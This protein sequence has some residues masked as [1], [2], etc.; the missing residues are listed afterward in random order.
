MIHGIIKGRELRYT[1]E[2]QKAKCKTRKFRKILFLSLIFSFAFLILNPYIASAEEY[3]DA[4]EKAI[5]LYENGDFD[6]AI[7]EFK[8]VISELR[9]KPEN[10]ARNEKLFTANF[11]VG[12]AY[13]G[14]G[15]EGL[16]KESFRNA[17]KAAPDKTINPELFPPKVISLYNEVISQNL[18]S[19]FVKSNVAEAE[20][21]VDD[22]KKGNAPV[23]RN[24]MPGTRTVK[25]VAAGQEIIKIVHLE[26]GKDVNI[27]AEFQTIGSLSIIS[28]PTVATVYLNGKLVG[29]TPL[30]LKDIPVGEHTVVISK[31]GYIESTQKAIVKGSEITE[32]IIRLAPVIYSVRLFSVPENAEVFWDETARGATPLVIENITAGIHK[33][34]IVKE[35][36]EEQKDTIDV[37]IPVTEKTYRLTPHTGSLSIKTDPPGVEVIIDNRNIGATPLTVS[38]LPV[39]Q[40]AVKLKKEGYKGKDVKVGIAKDKTAEINEVL[41]ELDAQSP[42]IILEPPSKAVKE[43]KNF[44]RARIMDNQAVGEVSLMLKM[45]GEMNFQRVGMSSPLKGTYEAVIPDAY[46]KKGAVLEYYISAC[47]LQSNCAAAG[48]KESPHKLKVISLEPYT[49]GFIIDMDMENDMVKISLGSVDGVKK[50]DKYIVFRIGKE[51][52]DPKTNELLQIEEYLIG[53]IKVKELMPRTASAEIDE[54]ESGMFKNDRVRKHASAV[55]GVI[56][57]GNYAAKITLRWAP[58]REPEV[59]GYRIYRSPKIDGIYQRAGEIDG[60]DNTSFEDTEDM[61]EGIS[62]YYTVAAFN[63]MGTD[64]I[65]SEPVLGKTKSGVL[66]PENVRVE[67]VKINQVH[68]RWSISRQDPDI[69][70]YIIFRSETEVGQFKE[71]GRVDRETDSYIDKEDIRPGKIYFYRLAGK[72]K[73]GSTGPLSR[74]VIASIKQ[75]PKAPTG[76]KGEAVQGKVLLR[77]EANK[78]PDIKGY[79]VYRKGWNKSALLITSSLNFGELRPEDKTKSIKLY[80]TALDNNGLES[81]PSEEIEITLQ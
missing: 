15:K 33:I 70:G 13:L 62:F 14:K 44:I 69:E 43:N 64:G 27:V 81:E 25:V 11:Y 20:I 67:A 42:E 31:S 45:E 74:A 36:H 10:D 17:F 3:P 78:E 47:D 6:K 77:W 68:L 38:A 5:A 49:E 53:V 41:M 60:R 50:G 30:Q 54:S 4:T 29:A 18:S 76:L 58:N 35:A 39:K 24:L 51:L 26:S 8:Q 23:I 73:H 65:K 37:Q 72:S 59:K 66:P 1:V 52:R 40:Y 2:I 46:L 21:F 55:A 56:T 75:R 28:E 32:V 71:A 7:R 63:M 48:S 80:V 57:E 19:L 34:R 16:A 79:N 22:V 12:M 61:K 9:D